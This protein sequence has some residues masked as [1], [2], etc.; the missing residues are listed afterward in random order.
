MKK[1]KKKIVKN[2]LI[3]FFV[4]MLGAVWA[5]T[6]FMYNDTVNQR[7]ES[8]KPLMLKIE[9]FEGL[10]CT[11]YN[12]SSDKGQM[13]A[14]FCY[15]AGSNQRGIIIIS[16]GFGGGGYNS[17]LDCINYF[18]KHGY[19][20]F[21]YDATGND[22]SE[23]ECV[24]GF[25]QG[26]ID[27]DYAISFVEDSG[28]FP[29]LP[30][31]LFGH[32]WGGYCVLS[33][34]TFH[35]EVKA[36]IACC[37]TNSSS[38]IFKA[39]GRKQ[40]GDFINVMIPF[41][42]IHEQVKYGNY[43]KNTAMDGFEASDAAILVTHSEDDQVVPI[44][45]GY[46]LYYDKYKDDPRFTFLRFKNKGH[47]DF[48]VDGNNNYKDEFNSVFN[49]W[50]ESLDYDY[51]TEEN[52]ERFTKDKAEFINVHLDREKWAH[53]LDKELFKEFTKFYDE[54]LNRNSDSNSKK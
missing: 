49:K 38:D 33:V 51:K 52:K 34:L 7:F 19:Y 25:P 18:A 12:F 28:N 54:Y 29:N 46:D 8:Y 42:K 16:H 22:K 4:L 48:F 40:A 50:A 1:S 10:E 30:I 2:I 32:S 43:A 6:V 13:L 44:Q 27:L 21:A 17:Y 24:G 45:Y 14:G 9:D 26:V 23:G 37:G 36:V 20:V 15:S 11:R 35:P 3:S 39:G 53:R 47:S 5:F 41:V 31:G